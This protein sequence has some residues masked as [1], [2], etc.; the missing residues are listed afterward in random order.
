MIGIIDG[1]GG[2]AS[3]NIQALCDMLEL[4]HVSIQHNDLC[5]DEWSV[6][7]MYPSP[8]AYNMVRV[9]LIFNVSTGLLYDA[10]IAT[11]Q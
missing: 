11:T 9:S 4:P 6:L 2:R 10:G 1:T 5:T 8:S 3:E 7:N